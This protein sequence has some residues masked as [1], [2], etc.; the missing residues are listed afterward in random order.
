M[1]LNLAPFGRWTLR[2]KA[3]QRRLALR[4]AKENGMKTFLRLLV[5]AIAVFCVPAA[6]AGSVRHELIVYRASS[7]LGSTSIYLASSPLGAESVYLST[8][9]LGADVRIGFVGKAEDADLVID[10]TTS[11][12]SGEGIYFSSSPLG[13]TAI[14]FSSTPL[15]AKTVY[16]A[17]SGIVVL[18]IHIRKW[19]GSRQELIATLVALK[20]L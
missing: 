2:E 6:S 1:A 18:R 16:L 20:Q 9:P 14:Y 3:A 15:G 5:V 13:A 19:G 8:S 11:P 17:T 7:S 10:E 12:L 4:W